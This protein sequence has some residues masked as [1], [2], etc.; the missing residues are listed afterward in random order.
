MNYSYRTDVLDGSGNRKYAK[1]EAKK[2][3]TLIAVKIVNNSGRTITFRNDIRIYAGQRNVF[4]LQGAM[5]AEQLH[6]I[7][8]LYLLWGF[9]FVT[10][11]KYDDYG[12]PTSVT[13]LPIG[14]AIGLVNLGI[15]SGA[16]KTFKKSME[17]YDIL[18]KEIK[19]GETG[20]GFIGLTSL[21]ASSPLTFKLEGQ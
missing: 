10:I 18:D 8:P 12:Q 19:D 6:Q 13:P 1:K 14:L 4:P 9:L 3:V 7:A 2:G 5:V 20:Y 17:D 21:D 15:A 16:N 11:T